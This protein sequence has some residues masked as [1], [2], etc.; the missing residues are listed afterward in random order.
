LLNIARANNKEE[1][2]EA[3][4]ATPKKWYGELVTHMDI[5]KIDKQLKE[6]RPGF[7]AS[8]IETTNE[9]YEAFLMD[10][11]K[12]KEYS[13]LEICKST[14][15]DWMS[16]L[17]ENLKHLTEDV[18]YKTAGVKPDHPLVPVTNI[19]Y[20]AAVI[21]C[22]WLTMTYNAYAKK[23]KHQKVRFRLP[24]EQEWMMAARANRDQAPYPW[25]GHYYKNKKGCYLS[26]FYSS[27]GEPCKDCEWK[28][29]DNDGGFFPV[30]ADTYFPNDFGLYGMS[31]NVAEMI[32][33]GQLAKGGSWEDI[34]E[35][36]TITA[37]K[38][39]D[40]ISP[41]IGF[42]VFMEVIK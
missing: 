11:L 33:G 2:I 26:N 1:K 4:I 5:K 31:G 19:S 32:E 22:D 16:L 13:L 37:Q 3:L 42:R 41:A 6:L 25:G 39:V 36:C 21:Y 40:G 14:K 28:S 38:A 18:V 17:P 15:V 23:K 24:T 30:I 10:L 9:A 20:E 12:S 8:S 27:D 29:Y 35:E 7:W 34:P